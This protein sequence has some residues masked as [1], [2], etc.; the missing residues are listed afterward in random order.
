MNITD[1]ARLVWR[2]GH[3][4]KFGDADSWD[5]KLF[6]ATW[7]ASYQ[8]K[9]PWRSYGKGWYWFLADL[10]IDELQ[11]LDR[12]NTLPLKGCNVGE[13]SRA[14]WETF[15]PELL[16]KSSED[17]RLVVYN[18]HEDSVCSRV[19]AHFALNNDRTGALGLRHFLLHD[20]TWEVRVF[21]SPCLANLSDTDRARVT[22]LMNSK[23]GRCAVESAWRALYGWPVLCK[24]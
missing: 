10:S 9:I 6:T 3:S 13:T 2:N 24:E 5:D 20:R 22:R 7:G 12:P 18:G 8:P 21:A 15:G 19:R 1:I 23:S 4:I 14:N 11:A 17:G 16:C